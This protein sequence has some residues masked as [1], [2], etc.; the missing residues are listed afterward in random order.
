MRTKPKSTIISCIEIE[1]ERVIKD[2]ILLNK[3]LIFKHILRRN[4]YARMIVSLL[5]AI[6]IEECR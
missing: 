6:S 2:E 1:R 5:E 4:L 3:K